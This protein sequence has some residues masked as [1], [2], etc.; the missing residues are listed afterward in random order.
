MADESGKSGS[1]TISSIAAPTDDI[2][3]DWALD[4]DTGSAHRPPAVSS[5]QAHDEDQKSEAPA[6][7]EI[8]SEWPDDAARADRLKK[9]KIPAAPKLPEEAIGFGSANAAL[10]ETSSV[11]APAYRPI[12]QSSIDRFEQAATT[13]SKGA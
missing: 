4:D 9:P 10:P 3:D 2:D 6:T 13:T 8:D 1:P 5:K 7:E 11:P 12:T